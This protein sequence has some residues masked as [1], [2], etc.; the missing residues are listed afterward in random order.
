MSPLIIGIVIAY[1]LH[2][3]ITALLL[4]YIFSRSE[5]KLG[6]EYR[7]IYLMLG[8]IWPTLLFIALLKVLGTPL[9]KLFQLVESKAHADY[10]KKHN[11]KETER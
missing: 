9:E 10:L 11:I 6:K 4:D 3:L 2:V 7:C 8:L 1:T 5:A